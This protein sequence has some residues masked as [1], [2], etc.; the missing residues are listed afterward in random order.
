M[1]DDD[2]AL[3]PQQEVE[4]LKEQVEALRKNPL[5]G[6]ASGHDLLNSVNALNLSINSMLD[7]FKEAA[8]T[9]KTEA[10]A[11]SSGDL[12]PMLKQVIEKLDA[13]VDQNKKI[14]KGIVAV[15]DLVR[16]GSSK[17]EEETEETTT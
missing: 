14:A 8:K 17:E 6:T 2:Y 5:A 4:R 9:M 3:V 16:E 13:V 11:A 12:K 15:A 10:P 1:K 7:L